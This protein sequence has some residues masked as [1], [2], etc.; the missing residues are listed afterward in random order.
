MKILI[1][2]HEKKKK[3]LNSWRA[4]ENNNKNERP[5]SNNQHNVG[6]REYFIFSSTK[7]K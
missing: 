5:S 7:K 6:N 2:V 3:R 1:G 4:H